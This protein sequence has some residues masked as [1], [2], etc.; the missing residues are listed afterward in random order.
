MTLISTLN[1]GVYVVHFNVSVQLI[2]TFSFLLFVELN[3][4][5]CTD[6]RGFLGLTFDLH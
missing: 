2:N 3:G 6:P 5:V 4:V 1:K